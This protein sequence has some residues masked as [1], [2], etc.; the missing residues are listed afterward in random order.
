MVGRG[1]LDELADEG[2]LREVLDCRP[3]DQSA[4]A[5]T[6]DDRSFSRCVVEHLKRSR[7]ILGRELN[8]GLSVV[9]EIDGARDPAQSRHEL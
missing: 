7:D 4:L 9:R 5:V 6:D 3:R 1:E 2:G 8:I